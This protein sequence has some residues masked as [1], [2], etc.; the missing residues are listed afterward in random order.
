MSNSIKKEIRV[1]LVVLT[2]LLI[3]SFSI[4][5]IGTQKNIFSKKVTYEVEFEETLGLNVGAPV[6][7]DG[8]TVGSVERIRFTEDLGKNSI[9]VTLKIDDAVKARISD[10]TVARIDTVGLLGDKFVNLTNDRGIRAPL[11]PGR[12]RIESKE[13]PQLIQFAEGGTDLLQNVVEISA[14]LRKLTGNLDQSLVG[15]MMTDAEFGK[16]TFEK[17]EKTAATIER[18]VSELDEGKGMIG[19]LLK[20]EEFEEGLVDDLRN[21]I[22][23]INEFTETIKEGKG[24]VGKLFQSDGDLEIIV[25]DLKTS[26]RTLRKITENLESGEGPVARLLLDQEYGR[27]IEGRLTGILKNMEEITTGLNEGEGTLGMLFKDETLYRNL[28]EITGGVEESKFVRWMVRK[29]AKKG[30]KKRFEE[31]L[32]E[33]TVEELI[34]ELEKEFVD[35]KEILEEK[36]E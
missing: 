23:N 1:G 31:G 16:K 2:A 14:S 3:I 34:E 29:L 28:E 21:T 13:T 26:A 4:V 9:I 10:L 6:W 36:Q 7:L 30:M 12:D 11:V 19:Q 17:I 25:A 5:S 18:I 15:R 24:V 22:K 32:D 8:V 33:W 35:E 20:N 27:E